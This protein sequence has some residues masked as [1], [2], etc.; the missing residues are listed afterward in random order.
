MARQ[1][2]RGTASC[3]DVDATIETGF[4]IDIET[5]ECCG[6]QVKV[7]APTH[8][9]ARGISASLHVIASI[10]ESL[11][12]ERSE[13]FGYPAVIAHILKHLKQKEALQAGLQPHEL[14]HHLRPVCSILP[15]R[16]FD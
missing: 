16:L 3:H 8:P 6:G 11:P 4:N 2:P 14:P 5:C 7:V 10:E 13:C 15:D 1:E 12:H 9:R